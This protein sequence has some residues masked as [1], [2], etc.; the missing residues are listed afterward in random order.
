MSIGEVIL[1]YME[2][3]IYNF[4]QEW[5]QWKKYPV[6]DMFAPAGIEIEAPA[7]TPILE[8]SFL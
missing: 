4:P 6:L 5:Y 3:Y 2:Q 8:P 1:K 7:A